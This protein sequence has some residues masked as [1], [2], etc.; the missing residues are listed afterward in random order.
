MS[1]PPAND[2]IGRLDRL[3]RRSAHFAIRGYQ[4]SLSML[5]GRWCRHLPT[6]S[7]YTD[8]AI[9]RHGFW[10]GGWIGAARLCRCNP[11][12]TSGFDPVPKALP[13]A[14]RWY[15]P[16][17]YGRWRSVEPPSLACEPIDPDTKG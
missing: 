14:A 7:E 4:L 2:R 3:T 13:Q 6:C 8:E 5:V 10:P 11:L 12:G 17:R 9:Q 16:W 1:M 15:T